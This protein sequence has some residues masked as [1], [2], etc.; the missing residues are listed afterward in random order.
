MKEEQERPICGQRGGRLLESVAAREIAGVKAGLPI[1][2]G[3]HVLGEYAGRAPCE[4]H[5]EDL[6]A[7]QQPG[8]ETSHRAADLEVGVQLPLVNRPTSLGLGA[9][10]LA[11]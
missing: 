3:L 1:K 5:L 2:L 10:L 8:A 6:Q 7:L 4:V 11:E 9:K